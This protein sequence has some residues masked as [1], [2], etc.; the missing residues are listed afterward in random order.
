MREVSELAEAALTGSREVYATVAVY[1]DGAPVLDEVPVVD[2]T[3][4]TDDGQAVQGTLSLS[5]P[6]FLTVDDV[7]LDLS[8]NTDGS[9]INAE[10]TQLAVTYYIGIPGGEVEAIGLGWFRI[11]SW[12]D[13]DGTVDLECSSLEAVVA[14]ARF[15]QPKVVAAGTAYETAFTTLLGT[16]LPV[17]ITAAAGKVTEAQTFE[18]DRLEALRTLVGLWPARMVV[19]DAGTLLVL[20]PYNDATDPVVLSLTDGEDG[21]V[22]HVPSSGNREGVY[23]AVRAS[24]EATGDVAPVSAIVYLTDGPRRWNGPYGNVPYF[25]ASPLITTTAQARAAAKTMLLRLQVQA[26]PVTVTCVPD[27]RLQTGDVVE[28]TWGGRTRLVRALKVDFP[29]TAEGGAMAFEG[30]E[31]IR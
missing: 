18:E 2:G 5:L 9:P 4:S 23:N 14:E 12:T 8:P 24:G 19:D 17:E 29:V 26:Q 16:L 11:E 13:G 25:F 22:V 10:G 20:P 31:V 30:V 7:E 6:R 3:I 21:T 1:Y 28:L 15:L 27:P